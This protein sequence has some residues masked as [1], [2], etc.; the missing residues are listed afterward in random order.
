M[1]FIIPHTQSS[2]EGLTRYVI[3]LRSLQV[4]RPIEAVRTVKQDLLSAKEKFWLPRCMPKLNML[5]FSIYMSLCTL[6]LE[7]K[8]KNM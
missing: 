3:C 8:K 5:K 1:I 2:I 6:Q 7:D 4:Q